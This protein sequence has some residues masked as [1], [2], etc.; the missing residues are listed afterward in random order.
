[1]NEVINKI[2]YFDRETIRNILQEQNKGTKVT[3]LGTASSMKGEAEIGAEAKIGLGIPF[4]KR[5]SFLFTGKIRA[6]YIV[7][8]DKETT[9]TSTDISMFESIKGEFKKFSKK[10]IGDIEN[11]STFFSVAS[12]YT[13]VIKGGVEGV[14]VKEFKS[15]IDGYNGYDIYKID[16]VNYVRFNNSAFVSN[17][18]RNDLLVTIMDLFCIRV[19]NF[20]KNEF[21]YLEQ[22]NRM[23]KMYIG[24]N[25]NQTL[26]DVYPPKEQ[27]KDDP[28]KVE[29]FEENVILFDVVYACVTSEVKNEAI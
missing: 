28:Q 12:N 2:I 5:F 19:G 21:N 24:P 22:I 9:I 27:K 20:S 29:D 10:K 6:E 3:L 13:R 25:P 14:E 4:L 18:K 7:K 8:R 1:M 16:D 17:Y 26:A 23:S 15:V 11:S